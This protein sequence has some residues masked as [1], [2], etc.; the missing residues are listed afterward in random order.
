[1]L[2]QIVPKHLGAVHGAEMRLVRWFS[3]FLI[4]YCICY[5]Y[6]SFYKLGGKIKH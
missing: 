5:C 4:C 3:I 6:L 1:M 2:L